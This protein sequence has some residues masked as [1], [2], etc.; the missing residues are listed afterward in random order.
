MYIIIYS[1][2]EYDWI[3]NKC[4]FEYFSNN[5]IKETT[6]IYIVYIAGKVYFNTD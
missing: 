3:N 1:M 5:M 4:S 2:Q 6:N